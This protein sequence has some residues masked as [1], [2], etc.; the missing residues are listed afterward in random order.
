VGLIWAA[1]GRV[2]I[3][4]RAICNRNPLSAWSRNPAGTFWGRDAISSSAAIKDEELE[5]GFEVI[6][7]CL[8]AVNES[9]AATVARNWLKAFRFAEWASGHRSSR[10]P[11]TRRL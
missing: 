2:L 9:L 3:R 7:R 10:R 1:L 4:F 8:E 6:E 5:E 11:K